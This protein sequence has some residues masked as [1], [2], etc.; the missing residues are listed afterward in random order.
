[1]GR[2]VS[3]FRLGSL[4]FYP[5]ELRARESLSEDSSSIS[6][7]PSD[8]AVFMEQVLL[9]WAAKLADPGDDGECG[10]LRRIH[11]QGVVIESFAGHSQASLR[12]SRAGQIGCRLWF[13]Q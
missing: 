8:R 2:Y 4:L 13:L 7:Q 3:D 1:M 12:M 6:G 5:A 11:R 10:L 9:S